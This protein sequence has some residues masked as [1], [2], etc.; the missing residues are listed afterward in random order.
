MSSPDYYLVPVLPNNGNMHILTNGK[1][2]IGSSDTQLVTNSSSNLTLSVNGNMNNFNG[3][4][5]SNNTNA[6]LIPSGSSVQRP[7]GGNVAGYLR[8]NTDSTVSTLEYY[9]ASQS[10]YLPLY[11]PPTFTTVS[12]STI[13]QDASSTQVI[14]ITGFNF[15][16]VNGCIV[17]YFNNNFSTIY[18]S[19]STNVSSST[20]LTATIPSAMNAG[21]AYANGPYAVQV[22][23]NTSGM[24]YTRVGVL[25]AFYWNPIDPSGMNLGNLYTSL[26]Y[27]SSS[28]PKLTPVNAISPSGATLTYSFDP[29]GT[30]ATGYAFMTGTG[31]TIQNVGGDGYITGT[32]KNG[33]VL[34]STTVAF[35]IRAYDPSL[36]AY[37]TTR[38]FN[39]TFVP[40]L[41]NLSVSGSGATTNTVTSGSSYVYTAITMTPTTHLVAPA[42]RTYNLTVGLTAA[43]GSNYTADPSFSYVDFLVVGGGGG[44]GSGWQGGGGGAGGLISSGNNPYA[45]YGYNIGNSGGGA[46]SGVGPILIPAQGSATTY[47]NAFIVGGGGAGGYYYYDPGSSN[48]PPANGANSTLSFAARTYIAIGG[49]YGSTEQNISLTPYSLNGANGG[50]GGAAGQGGGNIGLGTANQ[51]Y[52]G[53]AAVSDGSTGG[54]Y[55]CGGGG[56]AGGVGGNAVNGAPNPTYSGQGG[57]GGVGLQNSINGTSVYYAGGGGGA[58]RASSSTGTPGTGGT[59]GGGAAVLTAN[60]SGAFTGG[61]GTDGL[62]GGGGGVGVSS[63]G[64]PYNGESGGYGGNGVIIIRYRTT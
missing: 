15:D 3:P 9:R 31:L 18:V 17:H 32:V 52:N 63:S 11:S 47:T 5:F 38:V 10:A 61:L 36:N 30:Y 6:I 53:G 2:N 12:P 56:G 49:G 64:P 29:T 51:G 20:N 19:T 50:C 60:S 35:G 14:T 25:N 24:S 4:Y 45:S 34:T 43:G 62:G 58:P 16:V 27:S 1:A 41:L 57:N 37:L 8:Y 44:G 7:S 40:L 46:S 22:Q 39:A 48:T 55:I 42:T 23:N 28:N 54:H 21:T 59:G 33:Y 26:T 13:I